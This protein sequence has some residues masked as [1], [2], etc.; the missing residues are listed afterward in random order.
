[1]EWLAVGVL[2]GVGV[3]FRFIHFS[4]VPEGMNHDAAWYGMYA[5][6][7]N[8][9]APYTPYVAAGFGRETMYMYIVS[10]FVGWLGNTQEAIQLASTLCGVAA[11]VPLYL[12][13][14]AMFGTRVALIALAFLAVSGWH[15][16]F[17]RVGWRVITCRRSRC[18]RC[19]PPGAPCKAVAGA[20]GF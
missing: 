18:W 1:M 6:Y 17:S 4:T 13:A 5:I 7:I 15:G 11:L 8:Q 19:T 2:V 16:V 20:L 10:P 14:R 3:L 12:L 9:G